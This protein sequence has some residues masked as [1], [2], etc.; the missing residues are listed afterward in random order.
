MASTASPADADAPTATRT[1]AVEPA[2]AST[3][4]TGQTLRRISLRTTLSRR[5][6]P[7]P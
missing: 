3:T 4:S 5:G 7:A 6:S 2:V 1:G